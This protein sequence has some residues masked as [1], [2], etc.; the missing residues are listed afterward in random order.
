MTEKWSDRKMEETTA[1][2]SRKTAALVVHFS[3]PHFSV[4]K[5]FF[6]DP[7]SLPVG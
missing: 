1:V 6:S 4:I 3:V 7:A 5:S 2:R